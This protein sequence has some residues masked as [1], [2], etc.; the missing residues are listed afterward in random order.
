[1]A[2]PYDRQ[3]IGSGYNISKINDNFIAIEEALEDTVSRSGHTPNQMEA[4][5]DLNDNDLL[6]GGIGNFTNLFIDGEDVH[7]IAGTPGADGA[8]GPA[9]PAGADGADGV[10]QS[11]V[12]GTGISVDDTD[13]A[14][15]I[16]SATGGA[17]LVDGDY[18]DI[19]VSSSGT[20]MTLDAGTAY[21]RSLLELVDE[22]ALEAVLDTLPNVTSI[23]GRTVTLAD[24]GSD[25]IF[26]WDDSANA[27]TNL[28]ASDVRTALGLVI[29]IN[30]REVLTGAR[31]YYVRADGSD[32]NTGL[33]D[34]AGGAFLTIQ[35]AMDV[36]AATLDM[37]GFTVT[38]QVGTG[39]YTVGVTLKACTGQAGPNSLLFQGDTTT[40]SNVIISITSGTAFAAAGPTIMARVRGF[41]IA[42]PSGTTRGFDVSQG[43]IIN[44][45]TMD[46]AALAGTSFQIRA[47]TSASVVATG[48]YIIS[49]GA[50]RHW[51]TGTGGNITVAGRT[52]TITSTPAFSTFASAGSGS[53]MAINGNTFSGSATGPRYTVTGNSVMDTSS[54]GVAYLP[55]DTAGSTASGGQYL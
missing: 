30:V 42:G 34:S 52:V 41:Q 46:F 50:T 16:V 27:Y 38:V 18:G 13:P 26:G 36:I 14:N 9:G 55:G 19:V 48:N 11:V 22:T 39:T 53:T 8:T 7:D 40:P 12:A 54:G 5:F 6:N 31:T 32:S 35:K 17:G 49:G 15:P 4:D 45:D 2:V 23:Q 20:V 47:Q 10:V 24:A 1:M 51:I 29:G 44:F 28:S 33:V 37:A 43:A 25:A 21:G 3:N